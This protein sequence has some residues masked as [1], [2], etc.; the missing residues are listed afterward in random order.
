MTHVVAFNQ[1]GPGVN[2]MGLSRKHLVKAL[3][4]SLERLGTN[5]ID[6]YQMHCYDRGTPIRETL[7]ALNDFVRAGEDL[8][9][10]LLRCKSGLHSNAQPFVTN[11]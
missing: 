8:W 1:M 7:L 9:E 2:D 11:R 3:E 10:E 5:Y 6:L 4:A